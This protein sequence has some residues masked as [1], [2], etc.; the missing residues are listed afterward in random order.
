M[1]LTDRISAGVE[2]P[3]PAARVS[4]IND[5]SVHSDCIGGADRRPGVVAL[6]G[7]PPGAPN[8]PPAPVANPAGALHGVSVR[9]R[10][11][12]D[13]LP[14]RRPARPLLAPAPDPRV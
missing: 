4:F 8:P 5:V 2:R 14:R 10:L 12:D 13:L 7:S 3:S 9:L 1:C 6:G 11:L